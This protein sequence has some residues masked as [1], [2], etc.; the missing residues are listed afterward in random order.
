MSK[1]VIP[2][3][4]YDHE[5]PAGPINT[6]IKAAGGEK[7][8]TNDG[9]LFRVPVSQL[10][11]L[12]GFNVRVRGERYDEEVEEIKRSIKSEGFLRTRP[13]TVFAVKEEDG[14]KLY[15]TDGHRRRE[16]VIQLTDEGMEI[17]SLPVIMAPSNMTLEDHLVSLA[18]SNSGAPLTMFE[19]A[20][21]AKRL[22]NMGVEH[23]RIAERLGFTERHLHNMLVLS[24]APAKIRNAIID[25]KISSTQALKEMKVKGA[26]AS[27]AVEKAIK[28]AGEKGKK[29]ATARDIKADEKP[30]TTRTLTASRDEKVIDTVTVDFKKGD[31]VKADDLLF[32]ARFRNSDWYNWVDKTKK[33]AFIEQNIGFVLRIVTDAP[34]VE[35]PPVV[36]AE[37]PEDDT[38]NVPT[39]GPAEGELPAGAEGAAGEEEDDTFAMPPAAV[40]EAANAEEDPL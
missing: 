1:N 39:N 20:L 5:L 33:S 7:V 14:D 34:V 9:G 19:K 36:T 15:V 16:A 6:T 29:K 32:W 21:L 22:D 27:D 8:T 13:L 17:G 28:A 25:G 3:L 38:F 40:P 37:E 24:G 23:P 10:H 35:E 2:T 30:G 11:V 31:I 18:T 26:G 12:E 4:K